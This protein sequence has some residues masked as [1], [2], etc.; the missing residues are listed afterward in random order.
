LS[1]GAA[2]PEEA[3]REEAPDAAPALPAATG[4]RDTA[5]PAATDGRSTTRLTEAHARRPLWIPLVEGSALAAFAAL[6]LHAL[7]RV[8]RALELGD[9]PLLGVATAAGLL[10]ADFVSGFGHWLFDRY[11]TEDA[12]ILGPLAVRPFREHHA[13]PQELVRHGFIEL[14]G[15]TALAMLPFLGVALALP[16]PAAGRAW[17]AL[18]TALVAMVTFLVLT[19][20]LHRLAHAPAVPR[21]VAA[22]QRAGLLLSPERHARHHA[23]GHDRA[24]CITLGWWNP[25]LDRAGLFPALERGLARIGLPPDAA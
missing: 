9:L 8:A 11:L 16:E 14:N 5:L 24:Y 12:P 21:V 1:A 3:S 6:A 18:H 25:L 22:L 10:A 13:D 17:L 20:S 4:A 7:V 23:G 15:D 19:N 2:R